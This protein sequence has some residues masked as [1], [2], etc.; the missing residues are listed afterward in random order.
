MSAT[1]SATSSTSGTASKTVESVQEKS[2]EASTQQAKAQAD[3]Q[4]VASGDG[5]DGKSK[6]LQ[7]AK[8]K[9]GVVIQVDVKPQAQPQPGS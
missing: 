9:R 1:A 5:K 6:G 2:T 7:V 8:M 4:V 3:K